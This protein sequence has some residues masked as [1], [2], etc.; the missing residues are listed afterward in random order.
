MEPS[1]KP[2][3]FFRRFEKVMTDAEVP[4][5]Q[6]A[7]KLVEWDGAIPTALQ[8]LFLELPL[9][10]STHSTLR[11]RGVRELPTTHTGRLQD[12]RGHHSRVDI[13]ETTFTLPTGCSRLH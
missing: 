3:A 9:T 8:T 11:L 1:S 12:H 13:R 10:T 6:W 4:N 2:E 5:S 7:K